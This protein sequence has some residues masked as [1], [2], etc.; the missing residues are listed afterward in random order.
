M[1]QIEVGELTE[2]GKEQQKK[3]RKM[4]QI[5]VDELTEAGKEQQKNREI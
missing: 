2:A 5:E 3:Q 1:H 4:H